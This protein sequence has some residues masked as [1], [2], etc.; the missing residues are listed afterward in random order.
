VALLAA[1]LLRRLSTAGA[2]LCYHGIEHDDDREAPGLHVGMTE[3]RRAVEQARSL[4]RIVPLSRLVEEHRQGR[5][6]AGMFAFTFDDACASLLHV[7]GDYIEAEQLPIAVFAVSNAL[8]AGDRFWWDRLGALLP[9]LAPAE[10]AALLD[11]VGVPDDFRQIHAA[12]WGPERPLRQ[13]IIARHAARAP[14]PLNDAL[15]Q[16]EVAKG[17]RTM[18]RSMTWEELS[19]FMTMPGVELGVHT[20][21]HPALPHLQPEEQAGEI[22][23]CLDRLRHRFPAVLP[24][25]AAPF[26]LYNQAT[27]EAARAAGVVA[28]LSLGSRTLRRC[29]P[30]AVIPRFCQPDPPHKLALRLAGVYDRVWA[31]RGRAE[32]GP[33]VPPSV[34][35][36]ASG[37]AATGS[38][39]NR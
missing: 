4:G 36:G 37:G 34:H 19:R 8:D 39:P 24:V 23:T 31:L 25:L 33:P 28:T 35:A 27:V 1:P 13:W 32:A 17:V 38:A 7:A 22:V 20:T 6:T 9:H 11:S 5:S 10:L 30:A 2:V 14:Q 15:H 3:F 18:H 29:A 26:G 16:F 21:S 12:G